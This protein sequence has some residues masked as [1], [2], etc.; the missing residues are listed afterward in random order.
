MEE[1]N[2]TTQNR[3][4]SFR[5]K[6][7]TYT[8]MV[9]HD[10]DIDGRRRIK[11]AIIASVAIIWALF[12]VYTSYA[13]ILE[14]WRHRSLTLTFVLVLSFLYYP[15]KGKNLSSAKGILLFF[16]DNL[17]IVL[18][19]VLGA[20]MW[21]GY[22]GIIDREGMPNGNDLLFGGLALVLVLE[23]TRRT[24]GKGMAI[25]ATCFLG[26]MLLGYNI[27][28][29]M[30][31][32]VLGYEKVI[33]TMFNSTY[34]LFG[35]IIG[36]MSTFIIIF[37]IF[38]GF[39]VHSQA[40]NFFIKF[41]YALTGHKVGGPAKVAVVA[42]GF[43]GMVSGAAAANVATTGT[44]TIPLMKRV[45][46]RPEF[47]GGVEA[48]ASMGGQFMPPIMG[49]AAFLI[50]EQLRMPY[51]NLCWYAL[52]PAL[53]HFFA[54][55]VMVHLEAQKRDLPRLSKDELPNPIEIFKKDGHLLL[56][57]VLIIFL[58][59]RGYTPQTAG[60]WATLSVVVLTSLKKNTRMKWHTILSALE[61]GAKNAIS[62]TAVCACAG[63]IVGAVIMTGLGLKIS[64]LV[65][66]A[67][68]GIML[69]GLMF[70]MLTSIV[71]GM[72]MTTVSAYVILA[73][74]GTPALVKMGV[75]PLAAHMFVFYFAIFSNVTPPVAISAYAASGIAQGDPFKT[76]M[77]GFRICLGTLLLPYMFVLGPGLLMQGTVSQIVISVITAF[78][79]IFC[80][81]AALQGWWMYAMDWRVRLLTACAALLLVYPHV[82]GSLVGVVLFAVVLMIQKKG[83]MGVSNAQAAA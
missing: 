33:D 77:E 43:M 82:V 54:I 48:S 22:E 20:Y 63:I 55:G 62:I 32:P 1:T 44:F 78:M 69:L 35:L 39:L 6:T 41:A 58:L 17:G 47:A 51:V 40:G 14:A 7:P 49:A 27:P 81:A 26:Y 36:V 59:V 67:S 8:D 25:L 23:I 76:S 60:F 21:F 34:G 42:S 45:G 75:M 46:Y 83:G 50:A 15:S 12:H 53:L 31:I 71:L 29:A 13:G 65:L 37:V 19:L 5:V 68:G 64:R 11:L 57:V 80:L 30:G 16:F 73:V 56:P 2:N 70:I 24:V 38:G 79:G 9:L 61:T 74:L 4:P 66:E 72:G 10:R 52:V 28:G 3:K 18:S